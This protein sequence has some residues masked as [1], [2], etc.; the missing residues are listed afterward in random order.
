MVGGLLLSPP[1]SAQGVPV[2]TPGEVVA[3]WGDR[4]EL[5]GVRSVAPLSDGRLAIADG[6]NHR[7]LVV[8]RNGAVLSSMGRRGAGPGEFQHLLHLQALGDTLVTFDSGL[9]RVSVWLADGTFLDS[10]S[11]PQYRGQPLVFRGA[12]SAT[13]YL[14][15]AR[16]LDSAGAGLIPRTAELVVVDG[17]GRTT[18]NLSATPWSYEYL[19][20]SEGGAG[21]TS[22]EV[23]FLG[24][25]HA[26]VAA[27]QVFVVG[28]DS[29]I[30]TRIDPRS[31]GWPGAT[32]AIPGEP[33]PFDR[34]IVQLHRDSLLSEMSPTARQRFPFAVDRVRE[35]FGE[36][37]PEAEFRAFVVDAGGHDNLAWLRMA[38]DPGAEVS[39]WYI[40]DGSEPGMLARMTLPAEWD[41]LALDGEVVH[42]LKR[43]AF[44]IE[45]VVTQRI[46]REGTDL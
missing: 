2:W 4:I 45:Y 39:T 36:S 23:P 7:V 32:V 3:E 17:P 33:P 10:H 6:G 40:L 19:F 25:A 1:V 15:S 41:L 38:H 31:P 22:Y 12:V 42:L 37:F 27:G 29:G 43:D 11:L 8:S 20:V 14:A 35:V 34:S 30:V 9:G 21:A 26:W 16:V 28:R 44:G 5:F 18:T 46:E 13:E 24:H